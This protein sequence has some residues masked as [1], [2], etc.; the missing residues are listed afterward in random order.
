MYKRFYGLRDNPFR[1]SA[2]PRF[3][4]V[5]SGV[6]ET[7]AALSYG[8]RSRKGIV[9][10]TGE[11]GTGKT[12]LV[13][14]LLDYLRKKKAATAYVFNARENP[15]EFLE[16]VLAD[17]EVDYP[18]GA[19]RA[20]MTIRLNRWLLDRYRA[21]QPVILIVDEAQNL[22]PEVLE[23]VRL[24]TN[25]ETSSE[26]LLQIVLVGQPELERRLAQPELRQ[27][28]QRIAF[29]T[30]TSPL[31]LEQMRDYI[32]CRLAVA[33]APGHP[34]FEEDALLQIHQYSRGIPRLINLLCE[35]ALLHGYVE[36]K[37]CISAEIIAIA[38]GD[39]L[40]P[41]SAVSMKAS[42]TAI[43]ASK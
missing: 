42:G 13:N 15:T 28:A 11:V 24:L 10:L 27:L 35:H 12:T 9:L 19:S 4:Y 8:I 39:A 40:L 38:A 21:R 43:A 17:L 16:L 23:E 22:P 29:W 20:Q 32:R 30:K 34:I 37:Q 25:L 33:G 31:S 14:T 2:D 7:L 1:L 5:N 6:Q 41:L 3:L 36:D 18:A 26:K